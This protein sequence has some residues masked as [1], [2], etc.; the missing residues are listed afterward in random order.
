MKEVEILKMFEH[1]NIVR[2]HEYFI[3][4]DSLYIVLDE[5]EGET[6]E[7]WLLRQK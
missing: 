3:E 6:L 1:P 7:K 2:L 4:N 5:S